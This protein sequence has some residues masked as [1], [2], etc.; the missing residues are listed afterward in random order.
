MLLRHS[1]PIHIHTRV[2][3]HAPNRSPHCCACYARL[4]QKAKNYEMFTQAI[5]E[6]KKGRYVPV[7]SFPHL[8][9]PPE[10]SIRH[11][12]LHSSSSSSAAGK[13]TESLWKG[14]GPV[15]TQ[16]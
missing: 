12:T 16:D 4:L 14:S 7:T 1:Q 11:W 5:T 8:C 15:M 6:M 13:D 3:L 2:H 10:V 9:L